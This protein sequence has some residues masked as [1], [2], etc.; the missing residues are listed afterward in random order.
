[1]L[2]PGF[3]PQGTCADVLLANE[4]VLSK[5]VPQLRFILGECKIACDSI[6]TSPA[7]QHLVCHHQQ[8]WLQQIS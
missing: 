2:P 4:A 1:M 7:A 6:M 3:V 8:I 5:K